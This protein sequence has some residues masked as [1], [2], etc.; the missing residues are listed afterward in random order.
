MTQASPATRRRVF[1]WIAHLVAALPF[2]VSARAGLY[3]TPAVSPGPFY[4]PDPR[5]LPFFPAR[6]LRPLPEGHDLTIGAD[7]RRAEG[8]HVRIGGI[9]YDRDGRPVAGAR[10]EIWQ[11]D[12]RGSYV[13]E[14]G[15]DRDPGFAGYGTCVS[16]PDGSYGFVTIR[17]HGYGRYGGL[18]RRA[19]HIHLRVVAPGGAP[20]ATEIWFADDPD[21]ARD[22]FVSRVADPELRARML[23]AFVADTDGVPTARFDVVLP[24]LSAPRAS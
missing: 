19:A 11:V 17:P 24:E 23:V 5:G 2:A 1:V 3:P 13:V 12:A 14:T 8:E 20:L 9:V 22:S 21:N 16:G 7:G 18:I 10:V 4:P 6:P 15:A